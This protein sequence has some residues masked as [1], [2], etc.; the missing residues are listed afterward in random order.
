[1]LDTFIKYFAI[2][3][4]SFYAYIKILNIQPCKNHLLY[5]IIFSSLSSIIVSY[6]RTAY[7]QYTYLL[8]IIF[9][10]G[11]TY[12]IY[13]IALYVTI[14]SSIVSVTISYLLS[15]YSIT[16]NSLLHMIV[17]IINIE[18]DIL[19][20]PIFAFVHI[21]SISLIFR[22]KRFK[23]GMPFIYNL[24]NNDTILIVSAISLI[25]I[26]FFTPHS[27]MD[28]I[29]IIPLLTLISIGIF[30]IVWWRNRIT[31]K[32]IY[33]VKRSEIDTLNHKISA[34]ESRI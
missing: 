9:L 12:A 21:F 31:Q 19:Y 8:I 7:P 14:I 13:H 20:M 5:R 17:N 6:L 1:M 10:I 11:S 2:I 15:V 29:L 25:F 26:S 27:E 28:Y 16:I 33:E 18:T 22:I 4:A 23:N 34:L 3:Y 32:Y 24:Q 30:I